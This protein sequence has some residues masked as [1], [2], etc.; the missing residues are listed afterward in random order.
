MQYIKHMGSGM[1]AD[2]QSANNQTDMLTMGF[3]FICKETIWVII[4]MHILHAA[5]PKVTQGW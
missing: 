3:C 4:Y 2:F 5:G 1:L